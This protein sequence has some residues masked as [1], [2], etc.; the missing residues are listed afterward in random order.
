VQCLYQNAP[1]LLGIG[2]GG[3]AACLSNGHRRRAALVLG[4][5]ALAAL[6]MLP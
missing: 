3:A 6:S 2:L 1:L 5:G 4:I